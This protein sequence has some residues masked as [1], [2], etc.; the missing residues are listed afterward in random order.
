[1]TESLEV[2]RLHGEFLGA[3]ASGFVL[4]YLTSLLVNKKSRTS[5]SEVSEHPPPLSKLPEFAK[6]LRGNKNLQKVRLREWE[7]LVFRRENGW[8]GHDLIHNPEGKAVRILEYYWEPNEQEL[9][10][11]VWFGP[12]CESHRGLCHGGSFTSVLDDIAGHIA[13]LAGDSPWFGATVTINVKLKKPILLGSILRVKGKVVAEG[14]K[15]RVTA[16]LDSVE[17]DGSTI[18]YATLEGL[19]IAGVRL[20]AEEGHLDDQVSSRKWETYTDDN[21]FTTICDTGWNKELF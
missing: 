18:Q 6:H 11:V 1:M 16:S 19:S 13:F 20:V 10:G 21:G 2:P 9:Y 4:G 14:K 3:I 12:D 15:R 7:D 8:K 17:A 5:C